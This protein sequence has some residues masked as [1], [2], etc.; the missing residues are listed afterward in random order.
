MF[1]VV[2]PVLT[3]IQKLSK[4]SSPHFWVVKCFLYHVACYRQFY[5]AK[6]PFCFSEQQSICSCRV[7]ARNNREQKLLFCISVKE[8]RVC[9]IFSYREVCT[10]IHLQTRIFLPEVRVLCPCSWFGSYCSFLF[11]CRVHLTYCKNRK[12]SVLFRSVVFYQINF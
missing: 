7:R 1:S 6:I 11:V 9:P 12:V 10:V 8:C 4:H 3:H 2:F 5:S